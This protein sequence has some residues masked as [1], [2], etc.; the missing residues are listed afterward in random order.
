MVPDETIFGLS[1]SFIEGGL[2]LILVTLAA[3][4]LLL[5]VAIVMRQHHLG[6][7][8]SHQDN[9][10]MLS[11]FAVVLMLAVLACLLLA[12]SIWFHLIVP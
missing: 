8:K 2:P 6:E 12:I 11:S 1:R 7:A 5:F 4:L 3:L 9:E 10:F